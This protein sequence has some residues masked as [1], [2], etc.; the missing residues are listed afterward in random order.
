MIF[1]TKTEESYVSGNIVPLM[2]PDVLTALRQYQ[3]YFNL[4]QSNIPLVPKDRLFFI[5]EYIEAMHNSGN[6]HFIQNPPHYEE[7]ALGY[8]M[9]SYTYKMFGFKDLATYFFSKSVEI[10][11]L[12]VEKGLIS[13]TVAATFL[14]S[15]LYCESDNRTERVLFYFDRVGNFLYSL[16]QQ[17][18]LDDENIVNVQLVQ[19]RLLQHL[20][21]VTKAQLGSQFDV[22]LVIKSY[23]R[24]FYLSQQLSNLQINSNIPVFSDLKIELYVRQIKEDIANGTNKF[25]LKLEKLE[26]ILNEIRK[27]LDSGASTNMQ[28]QSEQMIFQMYLQAFRID[29]LHQRGMFYEPALRQS[30]DIIA[31]TGIAVA[32]LYTPPITA[33]PIIKAVSVH[34][35][36][37][38]SLNKDQIDT[39]VLLSRLGEELR[40]LTMVS[41]KHTRVQTLVDSVIKNLELMLQRYDVKRST[42]IHACTRPPSINYNF[43]NT[44]HNFTTAISTP[45][46][47]INDMIQESVDD[48]QE[49]MAE[50]YGAE[51]SDDEDDLSFL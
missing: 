15:A 1:D 3:M 10:L 36:C 20:Y 9:L 29:Q 27:S 45:A 32:R 26:N 51:L 13:F 38:E 21:L 7:V 17:L 46:N 25:P 50:L 23:L 16:S 44:I 2:E 34:L 39:K 41:N 31:R 18:P 37:L 33:L 4:S 43:A 30:A 11:R 8:S 12:T 35:H 28:S 24:S 5:M 48:V 47:S 22:N 14:Y 42:Y 6:Q 40:A 49:F 19:L